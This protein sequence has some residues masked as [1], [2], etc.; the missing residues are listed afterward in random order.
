MESCN[1]NNIN[2]L[3][4]NHLWGS[5]CQN[6]YKD[7]YKKILRV[8]SIPLPSIL[9]C[10]PTVSD[11]KFINQ[12]SCYFPGGVL[13]TYIHFVHYTPS[14]LNIGVRCFLLKKIHLSIQVPKW[15]IFAYIYIYYNN[16]KFD[17]NC[18]EEWY[19]SHFCTLLGCLL[20]ALKPGQP[21][22]KQRYLLRTDE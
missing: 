8:N 6:N 22:M 11:S 4:S 16:A 12:I 21:K 13:I 5:G 20:S 17:V 2:Q 19:A 9:K 15:N 10:L 3:I 18:H 14:K 1:R 7:L